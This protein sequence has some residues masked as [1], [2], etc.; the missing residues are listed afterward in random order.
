MRKGCAPA[1]LGD[2]DATPWRALFDNAAVREAAAAL[3]AGAP[4]AP[5]FWNAPVGH[6]PRNRAFAWGERAS[7]V[8]ASGEASP[9]VQGGALRTLELSGVL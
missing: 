3:R 5:V 2:G 8:V 7:F 9:Q 6:S 1:G 4:G